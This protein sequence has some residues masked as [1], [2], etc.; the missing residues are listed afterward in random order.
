MGITI[1]RG[2]EH[3]VEIANDTYLKIVDQTEKNFVGKPLFEILPEIEDS[4]GTLL[5]DIYKTGDAFH[6]YEFPVHLK[7]NEQVELC[8]F[9]FVYHPLREND[10]IVGIMVVATE[11][12]T[13]VKAKNQIEENE[14]KLQLIIQGSDLGVFDLNLKTGNVVSSDRCYEILGF[15]E[16]RQLTYQDLLSFIHPDDS[17]IRKKAFEKAKVEGVLHYQSR[18]IWSDQSLHWIDVKGKLFFDADNNPERI[19]GTVRDITKERTFQ[20]QLLEREEKFRLLADSLPQQVWTADPNGNLNYWN[21]TVFDYSGLTLEE[22]LSHGWPHMVHPDDRARNLK[23]WQEAVYSGNEF[24]IE[25]RFRKHNGEY[26]WQLS[27]AIPQ[28]DEDGVIKMW[29]GSSTD[30]QDQKMFTTELENQV[31]QRTNE[32]EQKNLDLE[33]MNKEL[34]SFV[35][36]SSHDLQEPLRKIQTFSSRIVETEYELL[37][38]TAKKY[39]TRMQKSAFRM[40]NLIQDLITYSR[41]NVQDTNFETIDLLEVIE[42]LKETL[43][44]ELEKSQV[45]F[46]IHNICSL[47][48]IPVQF[49]QIMHNLISNSIKF[50]QIDQPLEININCEKVDG[51]KVDLPSIADDQHFYHIRYSDNGIGFEPQYNNKIFEVFQRLHN[52]DAYS[53]TGIGL[54]IVKRIVENH[55]GFIFANGILNEG[56]RFDIYLPAEQT[57]LKF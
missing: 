41:A 33:K 11:V 45:T 51:K 26:R 2:P 24:L 55:D 5:S 25:H 31:R 37:S 13:T 9:N 6:G 48:V 39:F 28:K 8:Y 38:D 17:E 19:L 36:I 30:I 29:V 50:A 49:K 16:R 4:I 15:P 32:L 34:Q 18:L 56:T 40:Q 22:L 52:K 35:Y 21:K 7:R 54:A 47:E 23:E 20:Q 46:K 10:V 44:E 42:D 1:L 43:S 57:P 12:T 53:G 3:V 27:R 14:E